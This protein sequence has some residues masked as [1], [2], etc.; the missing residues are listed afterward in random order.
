M[1]PAS[2]Q[3][4]GAALRIGEA[5][6]G[7]WWWRWWCD[8]C[9]EWIYLDLTNHNCGTSQTKGYTLWA[10]TAANQSQRCLTADRTTILQH[11]R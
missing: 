11:Q 6:E 4:F 10:V 7:P 5:A 2:A 8:V 9:E 1:N 3:N